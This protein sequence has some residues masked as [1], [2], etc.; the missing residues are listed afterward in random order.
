[1]VSRG[2]VDSVLKQPVKTVKEGFS[3]KEITAE[4]KA[5]I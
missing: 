5:G 3:L 2:E 4:K 1:M